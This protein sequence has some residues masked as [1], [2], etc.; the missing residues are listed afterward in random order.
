MPENTEKYTYTQNRELSWLHFN[1]RVLE[2]AADDTVPLIERLKFVSIFCSNLDEF[3]MVRVGSLF[4]VNLVSPHEIDNKTGLTSAEQ[5][6]LIYSAVPCLIEEKEEIYDSLM[7][8]LHPHGIIDADYEDL[9]YEQQDYVKQYYSSSVLP[10]LSPIIVGSHHPVPHLV[11]KD[12]Y[13]AALLYNKK[14]KEAIGIIPVPE[15]LPR[16]LMMEGTNGTFIRM[17]NIILH[18]A[19]ALF[20]SYKVLESC[21]IAVTRNADIRFDDEKF[22]DSE[23]D[24]RSRVQKLLK[25]RDFLSVMRLEIGQKVSAS[26]AEALRKLVSME[27]NQVYFDSCPLNMKYVYQ[28]EGELTTTQKQALLYKP[29]TPRWPE[30]LERNQGIIGQVQ[31]KD[32]LLFFPFDSVNPF[33]NM[34]NEAADRPDVVSIK[35]TLYRIASLSKVAQALCRAA[36]NGK[37]VVVLIELRARFDEA[38]NVAWSKLMEESG[39]Q[40]IYGIKDYKC[41][42]KICLITM[43]NRG[44]LSYITQI[45]TGN[46]NE[47]T[48]AMY[49][50]LSLMTASTAIGEDA[51]AFFQ[52]M[53]VNNLNGEYRELLVSPYGIKN[54]LLDMMDEQIQKGKGGYICIK[55]NSITEREVIDKLREA[56]RAGVKIQLIIRSICCILPGVL[57]ETDNIE[58]TSIVG[59]YLEHARIYYFGH[60]EEAKIYIASADLMTRNLN[61]RVEIAAPIHDSRIRDQLH[62]ILTTQLSDNTKASFICSDGTYLRKHPEEGGKAISCQDA[63]MKESLHQKYTEILP[64]ED[65]GVKETKPSFFDWL[66]GLF[67]RSK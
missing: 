51:T 17:E 58:V 19:S 56:S 4:D 16:Y 14:E 37:Q 11:S 50:D 41:H 2:E 21:V 31:K 33:L 6:K 36:E 63:F 26:F 48:N 38:N 1:Q 3:F 52:N 35:I 57:G 53:L 49:T 64:A 40:V 47:K 29:Y 9:T 13:I 61:R 23:D 15:S 10:I 30:D 65:P 42:S 67:H 28:L 24:F 18:W 66:K 46:Y 60:G 59:R 5:L 54:G 55:A 8:A 25:K 32:R 43:Q 12:L 39:C 27:P 22:E 44:R 34:L 20:G 45:G 7:A 62:R